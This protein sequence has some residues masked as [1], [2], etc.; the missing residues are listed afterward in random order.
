MWVYEDGVYVHPNFKKLEDIFHNFEDLVLY[1]FKVIRKAFT[2]GYQKH[3]DQ[4]ISSW[5][6][7]NYYSQKVMISSN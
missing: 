4:L 7:N 6:V 2:S 1:L 3:L 5:D